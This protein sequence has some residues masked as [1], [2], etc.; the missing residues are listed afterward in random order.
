[1]SRAIR[2]TWAGE[3]RLIPEHKAFAIGEQVEDIVLLTD[4]QRWK[5]R[6]QFHKMARAYATMLRFSGFDV[7]DS[8]VLDAILRSDAPVAAE[9][10]N[11]L[12]IAL[13]GDAPDLSGGE[14][15]AAPKKASASSTKRSRSGSAA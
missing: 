15:Q 14:A 6:P 12:M 4:I 2:L 13:M 3:T 7:A 9:A 1:M 8:E 5:E 10:I 11:A